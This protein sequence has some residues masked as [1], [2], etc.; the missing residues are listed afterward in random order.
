MKGNPNVDAFNFE[1]DP[2]RPDARSFQSGSGIGLLDRCC[3]ARR[4]LQCIQHLND[5]IVRRFQRFPCF[6]ITHG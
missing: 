2:A 5:S 1:E 4:R 6:G 3:C